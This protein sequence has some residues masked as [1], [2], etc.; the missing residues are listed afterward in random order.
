MW[1]EGQAE[2]L[3]PTRTRPGSHP[4]SAVYSVLRLWHGF[5]RGVTWRLRANDALQPCKVSARHFMMKHPGEHKG[6]ANAAKSLHEQAA[7]GLA[8]DARRCGGIRIASFRLFHAHTSLLS[9]PFLASL[10]YSSASRSLPRLVYFLPLLPCLER[11][12]VAGPCDGG[13]G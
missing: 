1:G 10:C 7:N 9:S 4:A 12:A 6:W 8:D 3:V 13:V 2:L 5:G 11:A